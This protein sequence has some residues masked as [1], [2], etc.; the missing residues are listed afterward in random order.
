M[1]IQFFFPFVMNRK[2]F[3]IAA[4]VLLCFCLGYGTLLYKSA[5]RLS[6]MNEVKAASVEGDKL[7]P[8]KEKRNDDPN[9]P[10]IIPQQNPIAVKVI[11]E[12]C[13][14]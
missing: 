12:S 8:A 2:T 3:P 9:I 7:N 13:S 14:G 10:L 1:K 5:A 11:I 6:S 4:L